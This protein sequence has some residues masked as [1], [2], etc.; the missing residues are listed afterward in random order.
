[1]RN[2]TIG[3]LL[4]TLLLLACQPQV[5]KEYI[6]PDDME[7]ILYDYFVSQGAAQ[8]GM[9]SPEEG[10]Y[11][12]V[13]YF[14]AVLKKYDVTRAEFDSSLVYYYTR[15]DRFIKVM[16]NVQTRLGEDAM[17][18]GASASEVESFTVTALT[19]DTANIW[20]GE[21]S[22]IVVPFAPYNRMQFSVKADTAFRRGDS[23]M[24]TFTNRFLYQSGSRD[25]M[26]FLAVKYDNDSV[27]TANVHFST[28]GQPRV[29]LGRSDDH[30]VR[31]VS[32]FVYL[33]PGYNLEN[34]LHL[35]LLNDI[36]LIRFHK[37][38]DTPSHETQPKETRADSLERVPDSLRPRH[39]RLGER[40]MQSPKLPAQ[41]DGPIRII[42]N[43]NIPKNR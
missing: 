16:K 40:P 36:Q 27:A 43:N 23:F 5:P 35:L 3:I 22:R 42:D 39:H 18:Y 26:A 4:C 7:D 2:S 29:N 20:K 38:K 12:R 15:A 14:D 11:K 24:L 13:L 32:G 6:Q 34:T 9:K 28:D 31:E 17:E 1:M 41:P 10:D 21:L 30:D 25:A 37:P 19:G 33:G 8:E